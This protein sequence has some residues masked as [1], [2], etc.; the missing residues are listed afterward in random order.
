MNKE[1]KMAR[2]V[3]KSSKL[4]DEYKKTR[5][6]AILCVVLVGVFFVS[7]G[8]SGIVN[9]ATFGALRFLP[10]VFSI[11]F[12]ASGIGAKYFGEKANALKAGVEGE[13]TTAMI[14]EELP[15]DYVVYQNI[16]VTYNGKASELDAVVVGPTGVFIIETK[17]HNGKIAG[18]YD[19]PQ[20]VQHKVGRQGTPYSKNFYSPVKQVGTHV[21]RLANF[22]RGNGCNVYVNGIVY[23]ANPAAEVY[24]GGA[25]G[26]TPVYSALN[27]GATRLR[28]RILGCGDRVYAQDI[29]RINDLLGR[30]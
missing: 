3:K 5:T 14:V 4:Y 9:V 11:L 23:F 17:N 26:N 29:H 7:F 28:E 1:V 13:I 19:D 16:E 2:V 8:V 18:S 22:L 30:I 12:L 15:D 10:F 27:G 24:I 6:L 21:Y 20:W 25:E